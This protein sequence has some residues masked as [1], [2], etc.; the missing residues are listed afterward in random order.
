MARR[1]RAT[2]FHARRELASAARGS[3]SAGR[4][5]PS[6]C[7][8]TAVRDGESSVAGQGAELIGRGPRRSD[9]V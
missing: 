8:D 2:A 9:V 6:A 7:A 3:D 1:A 5:A 4:T